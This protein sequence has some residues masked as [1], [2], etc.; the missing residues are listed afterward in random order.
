MS[1]LAWF[2]RDRR[3][4]Q[5]GSVLGAVLIITA[6]LAIL[7]GALMTELSTNLLISRIQ[8]NR[9]ATEA[10]VNSALEQSLNDL[11]T[12]PL[13]N[14]C[15]TPATVSVNSQTAAVGYQRCL[16]VST[17]GMTPVATGARPFATDGTH[18][19]I[20]APSLD[21]YL[22]GDAGATIYR[23]RFGSSSSPPAFTVGGNLTGPPT[24][25]ADVT[26]GPTW[27]ANLVPVNE[28]AASGCPMY[29]V[30]L[31][32]EDLT[33]SSPPATKC[34]MPAGAAVTSRPAGGQKNSDVAF[35]GDAAGTL[36]ADSATA[37]GLCAQ[38]AP[39]V[40][41]AG[42]AVVAGPVV[43]TGLGNPGSSVDQVYSVLSNGVTSELDWYTF[44]EKK[45][46]APT[47]GLS[48]VLPLP[49]GSA[50]GL[51]IEPTNSP[52]PR[53]AIA[54]DGGQVAIVKVNANVSVV[55][56]GN[57]AIPVGISGA[58]YWFKG[59]NVDRVGVGGQD[60]RLY[61]LDTQPMT[62]AVFAG[63]SAISTA[64]AAD[65]AGDWFFGASD[66]L[67]YEVPASGISRSRPASDGHRAPPGPSA[68]LLS[69]DRAAW[70]C[71]SIWARSIGP[72]TWPDSTPAMRNSPPA[73]RPPASALR[74]R[75][76][77]S[78]RRLR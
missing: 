28:P 9:V 8:V 19:T 23:R 27:I 21:E 55:P 6:F 61:V 75:T 46:K 49:F 68:V 12:T 65:S 5:R 73:S 44:T 57:G 20:G 31:V 58:P 72:S 10:T 25:I 24:A 76:R 34:F 3:R 1:W 52:S 40:A 33:S 7:A 17:T 50:T 30:A 26:Q 67:L 63:P 45:G 2:P 69:W 37:G 29:C 43:L 39:P 16:P 66:G 38:M 42:W 62:V 70:I 14:G 56:S 36:F 71:A 60:G 11:Q 48:A 15:P 74:E 64:P 22:V 4:A 41:K 47:F 53:L 78:G 35:F 18:V 51:A 13:S 59:P 32:P 77:A 54:F